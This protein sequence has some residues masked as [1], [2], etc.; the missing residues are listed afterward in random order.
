MVNSV[1]IDNVSFLG[2]IEVGSDGKVELGEKFSGEV[3]TIAAKRSE[4]W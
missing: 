4:N 2:E 3:V 1:K